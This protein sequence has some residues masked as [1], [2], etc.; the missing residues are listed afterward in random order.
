MKSKFKPGDVICTIGDKN[1]ENCDRI[2]LAIDDDEEEV[3]YTTPIYKHI[4]TVTIDYVNKYFT[5]IHRPK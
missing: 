2:V 4:Y 1:N 5:L 3:H